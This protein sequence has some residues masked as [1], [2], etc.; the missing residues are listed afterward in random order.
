MKK[1]FTIGN[2]EPNN[3]GTV[4]ID[5]EAV[6]ADWSH[7]W[8]I[9]RYIGGDDIR[10]TLVKG[11]AIN[12]GLL[13]IKYKISKQDAKQLISELGLV[14][15]KDS[16]FRRATTFRREADCQKIEQ[17]YKRKKAAL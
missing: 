11:Y 3:T 13:K 9:V 5:I 14:C 12:S 6:K 1:N 10:Y 2:K 17:Y 4:E 16:V 7:L 15:F 8:F